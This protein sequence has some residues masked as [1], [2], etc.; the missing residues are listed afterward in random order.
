MTGVLAFLGR[1]AKLA[2][3]IRL[4]RVAL[5]GLVLLFLSPFLITFLG[6]GPSPEQLEAARETLDSHFITLTFVRL[7][8]YLT[9][10][11][12]GPV[13]HRVRVEDR[14]RTRT[15]LCFVAASVELLLVQRLSFF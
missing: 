1:L 14:D 10:I 4:A 9:V 12:Y 2:W 8:V 6:Y 15:I 5:A 7:A 13:W 3:K 11:W